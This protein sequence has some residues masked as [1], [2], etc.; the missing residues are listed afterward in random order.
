[1]GSRTSSCCRCRASVRS[2]RGYQPRDCA[3]T[4]RFGDPGGWRIVHARRAASARPRPGAGVF[5]PTNTGL[6]LPRNGRLMS[7]RTRG[8]AIIRT[9]TRRSTI[10]GGARWRASSSTTRCSGWSAITST[11]FASMPWPRCST[12]TTAAKDGEWIPN[13][14]GGRENLAGH[15]ASCS[16]SNARGLRLQHP[17]YRDGRRRVD[18][19]GRAC[20]EPTQRR[21]AW[22]SASSGTW[23][24][25]TTRSNT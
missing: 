3:P 9:G 6:P 20:R 25:C 10:S 21:A 17:A 4:S 15:Q 14:F 13:E 18:R 1:M 8:K 22:A 12:S 5:P 24:S 16:A 19:L 2:V 11:G 7:T 23:A